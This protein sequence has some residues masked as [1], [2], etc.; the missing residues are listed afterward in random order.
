MRPLT[1]LFAFCLAVGAAQG[2]QRSENVT[3]VPPV[4]AAHS[5]AADFLAQI[6]RRAV[7]QRSER[8]ERFTLLSGPPAD[9]GTEVQP[10]PPGRPDCGESAPRRVFKAAYAQCGLS[11]DLLVPNRGEF[12]CWMVPKVDRTGCVEQCIF[13]ACAPP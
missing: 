11:K 10:V 2:S 1:C 6:M 13:V 5:Q 9:D 4:R 12:S 7:A 3:V 8:Q